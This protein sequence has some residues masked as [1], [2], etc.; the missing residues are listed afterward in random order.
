MDLQVA[1]DV[2]VYVDH[3]SSLPRFRLLSL[4]SVDSPL[5]GP[6]TLSEPC[7]GEKEKGGPG[8]CGD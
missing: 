1:E 5:E 6:A 2:C 7:N 8:K 3:K 4:L